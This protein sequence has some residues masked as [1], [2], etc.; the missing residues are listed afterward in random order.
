MID[1]EIVLVQ[2]TQVYMYHHFIDRINVTSIGQTLT[3]NY[4]LGISLYEM[5]RR[6]CM[7]KISLENSKYTITR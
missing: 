1:I 6:K 3:I 7:Q 4:K 5:W 2:D